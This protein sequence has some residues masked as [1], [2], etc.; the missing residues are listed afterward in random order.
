MMN[1]VKIIIVTLLLSTSLIFSNIKT[2]EARSVFVMTN[3]TFINLINKVSPAVVKIHGSVT[4]K[5]DGKIKKGTVSGSGFIISEKGYIVT[6]AHVIEN[7][8]DIIVTLNDGSLARAKLIGKDKSMDLAV[9]KISVPFLLHFVEWGDSD[10]LKMGQLVLVMGNPLG[11]GISSSLGIVSGLHRYIGTNIY[12]DFIQTDADITSGNSGGPLFTLDGKVVGINSIVMGNGKTSGSSEGFSISSNLASI[13]VSKL[14]KNG[15]FTRAYLG[16]RIEP[17]PKEISDKTKLYKKIEKG[18][19]VLEVYKNTPAS[20]AG[21][22]I[23]DIILSVNNKEIES[24][25]NLIRIVSLSPIDKPIEIVVLRINKDGLTILKKLT[26]KL[27]KYKKLIMNSL[28]ITKTS[29]TFVVAGATF[30]LNSSSNTVVTNVIKGSKGFLSGL[31]K[32]DKVLIVETYLKV[33]PYVIA[34]A[35]KEAK[36]K[37]LSSLMI[38]IE[39]N[40]QQKY[41]NFIFK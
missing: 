14:I 36:S 22:K 5:K 39:R 15:K 24:T 25:V 40:G 38:L 9:I 19:K 31:Q 34:L 20:K 11:I 41:I 37:N 32:G 23:G 2:S 30:K 29:N 21:I 35:I 4:A 17:L 3:N 26:V 16:V 27:A 8:K 13:V 7:I 1:V 28:T 12:D 10:K 33:T 6:N 18:A